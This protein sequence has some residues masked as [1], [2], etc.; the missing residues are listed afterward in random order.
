MKVSRELV[1]EYK[2]TK[3]EFT[4]WNR[5]VNAFSGLINSLQFGLDQGQLES[6]DDN[7]NIIPLYCYGIGTLD[8]D[9][10]SREMASLVEMAVKESEKSVMEYFGN[11]QTTK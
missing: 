3:G 2:E 10:T 7:D 6:I 8:F 5:Q 11:E 1:S 9:L 4:P